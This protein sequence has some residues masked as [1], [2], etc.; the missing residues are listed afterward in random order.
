M[1]YPADTTVRERILA[2]VEESLAA[3]APPDFK[4]TLGASRVRRWAGNTLLVDTDMAAI[5]VPLEE[6]HDDSR[7]GLV[8]HTMDLLIVLGVRTL[9]WATRLPDL[10]A[11]VRMAL[12]KDAAAWTRGGLA[13]TTRILSDRTFDS[14]KAEPVAEAHISVR[15]LYRTAYA[16]P[17]VAL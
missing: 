14:T 16:D 3:I 2:N 1:T 9:H 11:D 6:S 7:H 10:I 13:L 12:T 8:Q 15:V 4:L 5:V 17:T